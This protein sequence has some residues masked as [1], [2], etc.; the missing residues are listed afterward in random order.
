MGLWKDFLRVLG[1]TS[2]ARV[3][4]SAPGI[5]VVITGEPEQVRALLSVVKYELERSTRWRDRDPKKEKAKLTPSTSHEGRPPRAPNYVQPTELDEMDSPYALPE[6]LVMP[7]DEITDERD[8]QPAS[9]KA[10]EQPPR[11]SNPYVL[12][13]ATLVPDVYDTQS[14]SNDPKQKRVERMDARPRLVRAESPPQEVASTKIDSNPPPSLSE[15]SQG[16]EPE[17]EITAVSP[18]PSG[19]QPA[20]A[21]GVSSAETDP[22]APAIARGASPFVTD[23]GPTL[24]PSTSDSDINVVTPAIR[25]DLRGTDPEDETK[26]TSRKSS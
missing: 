21:A 25:K 16:D 3:H 26:E 6:P 23:G 22:K 17:R 7:V 14:E 11:A 18:N 8:R 5:D 10:S 1:L 19:P 24:T 13:P 4:I 15:S 12:E 20:Q 2:D 9:R